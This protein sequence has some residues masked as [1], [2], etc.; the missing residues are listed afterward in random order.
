M[1]KD[2]RNRIQRATQA[3]RALLEREYS[4]QLG[5]VF[6]IRVDGTLPAEPGSHLD[7]E[8]RVLWTKLVDAVDHQRA[9]GLKPPEAVAS[10]LREAAFTML[11]RFVA[12]KMLEARGLVLESV[13]RGDQ[14]AGFKEF[15]G[16][17][18]GL[19]LAADHGYRLYIEALFDEI[20]HD[21]R[22]LFDRRD[23]AGLL[24]PRRQAL[25]DL[26]AILNTPELA[27]VWKD[28]E[29]I[30]WV[31]QYFNSDDERAQMRDVKRGGSQAPRNSREL[32][33]RNQFFTPR[34]VV[35][36]LT[37][38]TLGR[39]WYEMCQG[40]TRLV[41]E[42][43]YLVRRPNEVFL[44]ESSTASH[45]EP[46]AAE[47]FSQDAVLKQPVS[48]PFRKKKD[49]RDL[50]VLDPACGS[51]H[52]LLYAFNVL[53]S[54]YE[55]AWEDKLDCASEVT[56]NALFTDY[57][58]LGSLHKAI[59]G[60][61]LR[62]NIHGI[63]IDPR[64]V[65]I[66]ALA[67]WMRAQRAENDYGIPRGD[68]ARI[69]RTNIVAAEPL[70]GEKE[71]R[72]ELQATLDKEFGQLIERIFDRMALAGEAGALLRIEDEI[73]TDIRDLYRETGA[74]FR[75]SDEERWKEVEFA[76]LSALGRFAEQAQNGRAYR[77]RLFAEDAA[78]G[79]ALIGI[80]RQRYDTIL[81][82]PPFGDPSSGIK[83]YISSRYSKAAA[84]LG[85]VFVL[86]GI[87]LLGDG[88]RVGAITN[89]TLLAVQGFSEWRRQLLDKA[90]LHA[91][92]DLGHGVLDAMVETAMYVCGGGP[93][94]S[95]SRAVFLGLLESSDKQSDL[96]DG[97][98]HPRSLQWRRPA[99]FRDVLGAPW[100][101]WVPPSLLRRFK[102]DA[103]FLAAS[104]LVCQ[105]T[106]TADDFRFYR[107]RWE[108][109]TSEIHV[110]PH[111]QDSTFCRHRWSPLA[112]GGEYSLWWDDI[113][114]VQDWAR[115]GLQVKNFVEPSG[116]PRSFPKNLDKLFRR[117]STFPYRT[118]SAFG[119]R[120][121]PPGMSFSVGGW[122]MFAPEGWTDEE[123]L[124]TYNTRIAR[125]FMEVLL[126]QG[127]SSAA[128]TA[129]RNHV[130]AAVGGIPWPKR[131]I[132]HVAAI[133]ER[134]ITKAA[135]ETTDETALFF[136]GA[137]LFV[138]TVTTFCEA[139]DQWWH[140]QCDC[141][142]ETANLYDSVEKAVI[143]A[144]GLS[145]SDFAAITEAEG[146]PLTS[147]P[148]RALSTE[149]VGWIFRST[150][151]ELTARAKEVCGAKRYTVK[152]AY[153]VDR[154]V[155]LGCHILRAHPKSVIE[156]ARRAG[157]EAC[158][159]SRAFA[160]SLLS[161][162]F[163]CAVGRFRPAAGEAIKGPGQ[164]A[165][166]PQQAVEE[167]T[168]DVDI[169]VDD[170]GHRFDVVSLVQGVADKRWHSGADR[171]LRG[172]AEAASGREE[173]RL[174]YR[175]RFFGVHVSAYSKSRRK[176]P[177][178][179]QLATPSAA[180][181]VWLSY[182]CLTKDSFYK[183][184]NDILG[185]KLQHEV[186]KLAGMTHVA[187]GNP[188]ASQREELAE[189]D[190]F[191]NELRVLHEEVARIAPLWAPNLNDGVI[192]NY[193]PLWRLVPQHRTWQKECRE[194]WDTLAAGKY[195]WAH[196]A[197]HLWPERVVPKCAD[198]RSLAIAHGLDEEFW[199]QDSDGKWQMR[200]VDEATV[201]R[202]IAERTSRA[203][204]DA[205]KNLL[206][207]PAPSTGRGGARRTSGPGRA[208]A[209]KRRLRESVMPDAAVAIGGDTVDRVREAIAGAA[210]GVS[211]ADVI[212][213]TGITSS[214]WNTA[215]KALLA[216]GS[217]TQTG[218]RRGARYHLA[219]GDA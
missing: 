6:D 183:V 17:A 119:L 190:A 214:Q 88:G 207:A 62:H 27:E 108:V 16:L 174:W 182:H 195:D 73:G 55:E 53:L 176:A 141:W 50:R 213:A 24:W 83:E 96:G 160:S 134:L 98:A 150:V 208:S 4:E 127:D 97:L 49:P 72:K 180:Y 110:A 70:P 43:G 170:P 101:Y 111:Q 192:I 130:A 8:Q 194:C 23:P 84:D 11:N 219:G 66:A 136:S 185:P 143:D 115:D 203:V 113:H 100:A 44:N 12:L 99:E 124:A 198:D 215:I 202:L 133:V 121:L 142:M 57:P 148:E 46:D 147:Y 137:R 138:P 26:L 173:L 177:I 217:V 76:L 159:A 186:R 51:G 125:Y 94:A 65:Q 209:P 191:V 59:P 129:A 48:V 199:A 197:M 37:D 107:L 106:A 91:L 14:S 161:W 63:D 7:S 145:P 79:F 153:F 89:R 112:K 117:G 5:G 67:L 13:S 36:F 120:F 196:L 187:G 140:T 78:H 157:A 204:K 56:G 1:D 87:E 95:D 21:V 212:D 139:L 71:L 152:K 189:Q 20:G 206:E 164:R 188:S 123:V 162:L 45:E 29:T 25:L 81:M 35:E 169:W 179:W 200:K 116:K 132:E 104:G 131:R 93:A 181:S 31:Y 10:Y 149:E 47:E 69:L 114:L 165:N 9:G 144:F 64:A 15:T 77:R 211:R 18:P 92:V 216:D 102:T 54:I 86:R 32:A 28:D 74:L 128:G 126:G 171:V 172:A 135:L 90:G 60:L 175:H 193:S 75:S 151:G 218:E 158:G 52:F 22:V 122:A 210:D 155:D 19:V 178:Y 2:T 167:G 30:G 205:L 168:V 103:N 38:N 58:D 40:K 33:V 109:P 163:G 39:I 41:E 34:Y 156:S 166:L 118:T 61:I 85:A 154:S 184:L 68:R 3:A 146:P 105:G 42:C 80:C 201:N 82:N